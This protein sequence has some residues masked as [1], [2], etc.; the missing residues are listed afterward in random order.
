M[1]G[2]IF[3]EDEQES[4]VF[5]KISGEMPIPVEGE[6]ITLDLDELEVEA[7]ESVNSPE[8]IQTFLIIEVEA[9][10]KIWQATAIF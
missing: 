8:G 10:Q 4:R 1:L 3:V 7:V 9:N 2:T 6:S 5:Y